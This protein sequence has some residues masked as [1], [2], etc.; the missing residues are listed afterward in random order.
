MS[1]NFG[2]QELGNDILQERKRNPLVLVGMSYVSVAGPLN[3]LVS[4]LV[5]AINGNKTGLR[6]FFGIYRC[7]SYSG[8]P[9]CRPS[10]F[11]AGD[12]AAP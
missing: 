3:F 7:C 8:R 5:L 11:Q 1:Q 4:R 2:H 12:L 6:L 10:S 9:L